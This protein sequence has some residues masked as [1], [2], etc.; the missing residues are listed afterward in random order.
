M[1]VDRVD[2]GRRLAEQLAHLADE[3]PIVFALPRGGV[4]VGAEIAR[5]LNAPLDLLIVRKIGAPW[6]PELAVGAVVD[7]AQPETV[8]NDWVVRELG[9]SEKYIEDE[10]TR[11]L[12]EIERRRKA[13]VGDRPAQDPAGRTVILVDDGIATGATV[14]AALHALQRKGPRRLVL[15]VPVA[16]PETIEALRS[17]ADEVY[18]LEQPPE[19]GAI[20]RF[21]RDFAQLD[22]RTVIQL[23]DEAAGT[24]A[25]PATAERSGE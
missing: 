5:R 15:A 25:K 4:P 1:F 17:E 6:Q 14:R 21:Y 20:G 12:D 24:G 13:Y 18:C 19:F 8:L 9:I 10:R 16:P 22:D 3:Q 2:A 11:Q 23:L 7:G